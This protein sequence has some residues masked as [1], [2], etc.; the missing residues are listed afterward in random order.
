MMRPMRSSRILSGG[1]VLCIALACV[2]C[3]PKATVTRTT[4]VANLQTYRSALIRVAAGSEGQGQIADLERIAADKLRTSCQFDQVLVGQAGSAPPDLILDLNIQRSFRGGDG[5]VQNPNL[6]IV[7]VTMV[8]SDGI[9]D[10]L[11][12]SAEMRGQSSAVLV[13]GA[14]PESEAVEA[15][16]KKIAEV[17]SKSGCTG[18]RV[19]RAPEDPGPGPDQPVGNPDGGAGTAPPPDE[20]KMADAEKLNDEGKELFRSADISQAKSK[21]EQAI[22]LFPDARFLFNL[23]LAQ[24]T[25]K[26]WDA[27]VGT[28][29]KVLDSNP[30]PRL[31][32]KAQERLTII[33]DKRSG[34]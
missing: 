8:L 28:C 2:S 23:C 31:A 25:L 13:G 26:E 5:L 16:A 20:A 21:F 22:A 17:M 19:A 32:E 18:P 4:P 11:I 7:D 34:G 6:A 27:A 33:A 29:Q 12:G 10:D 30:P 14:L 15:V 24:E 1:S 9:N 3:G